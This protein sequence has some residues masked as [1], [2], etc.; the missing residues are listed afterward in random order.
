MPTKRTN[1]YRR[2][3]PIPMRLTSRDEKI[4]TRCFEDKL[5]STS[6]ISKIFNLS[7]PVCSHRLRMLFSNHYLDRYFFPASLPY[8]GSSEAYYA[9]GKQGIEIAAMKIGLERR[10]IQ[11]A[12]QKLKKQLKSYSILFT[13]AHINAIS[14]TRIAFERA[15][16]KD[17]EAELL[18]WI[19][20]RLLE[21][22]FKACPE[23]SRR[24]DDKR[25][26]LRP[27]GF[28]RYQ[29]KDSG[30]IYSAFI[31]VDLST[32]SQKQLQDKVRRYLAF[33]ETDLPYTFFGSR[34][35]RVIL[36]SKSE[37]RSQEIKSA[38]ETITEKIFWITEIYKIYS[39]D[40]LDKPIFLKVGLP[41]RFS[42]IT[43]NWIPIG[44]KNTK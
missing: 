30:K 32:Q 4:I 24:D 39:D 23:C 34:W 13:L 7:L 18:K 26:K 8:L 37:R 36:V 29:I 15:F 31:E 20:E 10:Y 11:R 43:K 25:L 2:P 14:K 3:D 42:L 1:R 9:L 22:R 27:D 33:S 35:F 44:L 16:F 21:Q 12:R 17:K 6:D 41:G 40:W 38:I 5:I 28:M 19:P